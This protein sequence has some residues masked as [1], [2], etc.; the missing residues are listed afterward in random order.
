MRNTEYI[1]DILYAYVTLDIKI[2]W[3]IYNCPIDHYQ[4]FVIKLISNWWCVNSGQSTNEIKSHVKYMSYYDS[5]R[6]DTCPSHVATSEEKTYTESFYWM[7][8]KN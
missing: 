5:H 1:V 4:I 7:Q 3:Y 2:S 6:N 8:E